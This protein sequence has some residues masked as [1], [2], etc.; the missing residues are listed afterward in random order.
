MVVDTMTP[1]NP[2]RKAFRLVSGVLVEKTI[3]DILPLLKS[4]MENVRFLTSSFFR[5]V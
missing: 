4:N 3:K 1:L 2:E 5:D